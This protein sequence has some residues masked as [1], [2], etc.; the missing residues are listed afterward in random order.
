MFVNPGCPPSETLILSGNTLTLAS[1]WAGAVALEDTLAN[2]RA[3]YDDLELVKALLTYPDYLILCHGATGELATSKTNNFNKAATVFTANDAAD[4]YFAFFP[5]D[6][7]T[8]RVVSAGGFQL[9][10]LLC[11]QGFDGV[12][13]NSFGP[14]VSVDVPT[15]P[16]APVF[17]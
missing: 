13:F 4:K 8:M 15:A 12:S 5:S 6:R 7:A 16:F 9:F 3:P 14:S 10:R 11:A 17:A 2:A 1:V